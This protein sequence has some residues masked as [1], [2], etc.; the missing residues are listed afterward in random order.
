[1]KVS[2]FLGFDIF[3]K[4]WNRDLVREKKTKEHTIT[5]FDYLHELAG[6]VL[7]KNIIQTIEKIFGIKETFVVKTTKNNLVLGDFTLLY[8]TGETLKNHSLVELYAH[9]VGLFLDRNKMTNSLRESEEKH[10][11]LI[12][13]SHD[14]IYTLTPEGVFMYVSSAWTTL[15]GHPVSQVLGQSFQQFVHP[16]DLSKCLEFIEKVMTTGTRQKGIEYR[17]QHVNKKWYWH[18]SSAVPIKDKS[19]TVIGFEG[20]A[21]DI[22]DR[23]KSEEI[24]RISSKKWEA[25]IAASPDG[26]GMASLDGKIEFMSEKLASMYG[27]TIEE[28]D[29]S[30]GNSLF[31]FIEPS[32]HDLLK[33]NIRKLLTGEKD[34]KITE[35]QGIKKDNSRFYVDVNSTVLYNAEGNPESILFVERDITERKKVE[36][37]LKKSED[38]FRTFFDSIADLLFVLDTNGNIVDVNETVIKRL[39]F[40]KEELIGQSVLVVHPE[41]RRQE[42]GAIV[43]EMLAGTKDFCPIPVLSKSGIEIQVETRVYPGV[44]DEEPA[45]YGVVKDI[46][47]MKQSEE[48]FSKAFQA[49]SNLMAISTVNTGRYLEVN[50]LFLEVMEFTKEEV[51]GKTTLELNLFDDLQQREI[52]KSVIKEKGFVS[53]VEVKIKTKSGKSLIGLFSGAYISIG[54]ELCLLTTMIDITKK[55]QDEVKLSK[56]MLETENMNRLMTGREER[57]L[58]LKLEIN[59]LLKQ[60][61]KDIKYKSVED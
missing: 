56:V 35:Y 39:E 16:D 47:K 27:Y 40:T 20:T 22:T 55:K 46:T 26:I 54:D 45:L 30:I 32:Y 29:V 17:V 9:Q 50:D 12:D 41:N 25:I 31:G 4:H 37:E 52:I 51:I 61:G 57:I 13:N 23:K 33:E 21:R 3:N 8:K 60:L 49:G 58:E 42:A 53:N 5:R 44:W 2:S 6:N 48:K 10:R 38:N 34:Q 18:T 7:S 28:K 15:L 36:A 14:I 24:M 59:N 11:Q 19:G 43:A 1:K